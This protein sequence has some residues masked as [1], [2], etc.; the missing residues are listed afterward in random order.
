MRSVTLLRVDDDT[1]RKINRW[2]KRG[3]GR[4]W[5]EEAK[6][7]VGQGVVRGAMNVRP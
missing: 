7:A 6:G 3:N 4:V 1:T 2:E 5:G